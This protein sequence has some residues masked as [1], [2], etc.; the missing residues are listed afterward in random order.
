MNQG[1]D[2]S[3]AFGQ[4][5]GGHWEEPSEGR[6]RQRLWLL[7]QQW[8]KSTGTL[9]FLGTAGMT[10]SPTSGRPDTVTCEQGQPRDGEKGCSE[11][12]KSSQPP[13][14]AH[15]TDSKIE[16]W[17]WGATH[18]SHVA[19]TAMMGLW[20]VPSLSFAKIASVGQSS[21]LKMGP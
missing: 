4:R 16:G 13:V 12:A 15:P 9:P 14:S 7:L 18:S 2:K 3:A 20:S 10:H 21:H 11:L 1:A 8:D 6:T 5:S 19:L 17:A